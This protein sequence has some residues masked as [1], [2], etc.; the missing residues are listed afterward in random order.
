MLL[1]INGDVKIGT[2]KIFEKWLTN[3]NIQKI[4]LGNF[5]ITSG[6]HRLTGNLFSWY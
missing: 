1:L 3:N 5:G 6:V 2:D 4:Y